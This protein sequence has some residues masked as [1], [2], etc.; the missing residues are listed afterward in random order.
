MGSDGEVGQHVAGREGDCC[1]KP[2]FSSRVDRLSTMG[3]NEGETV[4]A[5]VV[6]AKQVAPEDYFS[7][8]Y[9]LY[10]LAILSC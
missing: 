9:G 4:A 8:V 3:S 10:I 1:W 6:P 7:Q 2:Y 5:V